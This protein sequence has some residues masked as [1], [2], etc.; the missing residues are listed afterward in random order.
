MSKIVFP[1]GV[2]D[3]QAFCDKTHAQM[4]ATNPAYAKSVADGQT[5]RWD[6]PRQDLD[7]QG[8]PVGDPYVIV[9]DRIDPTLT[10]AERS[11]IVASSVADSKV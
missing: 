9:K 6:S 2:A 5:A 1:T 8:K 3:A 7:D 11:K 4:I 10:P